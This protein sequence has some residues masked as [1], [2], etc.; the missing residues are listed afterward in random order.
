MRSTAF[1]LLFCLGLVTAGCDN[2]PKPGVPVPK[3]LAAG[4][5]AAPQH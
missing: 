3:A 5:V 2:K 4:A 1:V